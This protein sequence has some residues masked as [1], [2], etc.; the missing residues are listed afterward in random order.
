MK[1]FFSKKIILY[2]LASIHMQSAF[3]EENFNRI[4]IEADKSIEYFENQKIY[5]ASGNAK[6]SKGSLYI[7]ADKITAFMDQKKNSSITN[8]E[9]KGKVIIKNNNTTAKSNFAMYDFK[10]KIIILKGNSQSIEAKKF[11]LNSKKFISFDD[12]NKV[13][14]SEGDVKLSLEGPVYIFSEKFNA[15]F[16]KINN[17]LTTASAKGKVKIKT[18]LETITSNS[19]KYERKTDLIYLKGNVIIKKGNSV[20]RGEKGYMNLNTR[21]SKIESGKSKRVKGVFTPFKK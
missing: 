10:K 6:A 9:A 3:A 18:K 14:N 21:K 2:L 7:Q 19:A 17:T 4:N 13:A 1:I 8:I 11:K 15:S 16:S 12:V 5:I 20:L